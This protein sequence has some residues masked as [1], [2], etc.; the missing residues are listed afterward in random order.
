MGDTSIYL[1]PSLISLIDNKA[2]KECDN[3]ALLYSSTF[4]SQLNNHINGVSSLSI[5]EIEE[6][7]DYLVGCLTIT[8]DIPIN[9]LEFLRVR[10]CEGKRFECV[11][12]LS[13]VKAV[14]KSFP[15][16]G[17]MNQAGQALFYAALS[18]KKDDTAL[19]V[20]LSEAGSKNLD[21]LNVLRSDQKSG[22]DLNI[23]VIGIWD[24]VRRGSQP[25]YLDSK[26]FN[27]YEKAS[28]YMEQKFS[29]D[30][31]YAYQL[32]DRFFADVLSRKGSV[33]LYQVTSI[34]S[35]AI[36]GGSICEGILYTSV[37]AEGEPVVA[38]KPSS[39][40]AKLVH[41]WAADVNI[42]KKLGYEFYK[43]RTLGKTKSID[44]QSGRLIW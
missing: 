23:R 7:I 1:E 22:C 44:V 20:A 29:R 37:E 26:I 17:R 27:Y 39:V 6:K 31:L 14:T 21:R 5:S 19:R 10:R 38:L 13:Y 3:T 2:N 16:Q 4:I 24:Q 12:E 18:V 35:Y 32:T 42:E 30:L 11:K 9:E 15:A 25:Y 41:Q 28:N 34:I 36:L 33:N 43:Y 40:D 8:L